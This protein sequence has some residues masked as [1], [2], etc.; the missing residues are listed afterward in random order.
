MASQSH[1]ARTILIVDDDPDIRSIISSIVSLLGH[2]P[3]EVEDGEKALALLREC[4]PDLIILDIMMPGCSGTDVCR[5]VRGREDGEF[6]P[7]IMVT[8]R[9]SMRDK[10]SALEGGAD[11]YVTKPFNYQEL[12]ARITAQLRIRDLHERLRE[13][14][15]QLQALQTQLLEQERQVA[16][17]QVAGT[18]AHQLGQPLSAMILNI[19]LLEQF[20]AGDPRAKKALAALKAD[21]K[22]MASMLEQLKGADAHKTEEYF[23]SQQ[24]LKVDKEK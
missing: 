9:D 8:A 1:A 11:D 14:N 2:A 22:R 7:I 13:R 16:V 15:A 17:G 19:H 10:I 6:V 3:I 20:P 12:Q 24:I 21:A 4:L 5:H 23:G 18:A